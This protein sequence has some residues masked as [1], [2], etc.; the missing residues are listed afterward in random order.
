MSLGFFNQVGPQSGNIVSNSFVVEAAHVAAG[1]NNDVQSNEQ[2]LILPKGTSKQALDAIPLHGPGQIFLSDYQAQPAELQFVVTGK[3]QEVAVGNLEVGPVKNRLELSRFGQPELP[4]K[5][6]SRH[7]PITFRA[8]RDC[9][10]A[11]SLARPLERRRLITSLPPFVAM[12][13]RKP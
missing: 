2:T 13:A 9:G 11:D 6:V 8:K 7:C 10:Y 1:K 4:G 3:H 12:R 5:A